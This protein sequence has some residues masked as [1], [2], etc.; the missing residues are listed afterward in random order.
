MVVSGDITEV[1]CNHPTL[2]SFTFFPKAAED[3]TYDL[4]GFRSDDDKNLIDGG[5]G[6]IDK[7]N[8]SRWFFEVPLAS[9]LNT[10][11]ELQNITNLAGSPVPGEWT[12]AHINGTVFKGTGKPVGDVQHNGNAGT[13]ALKVSGGGVMKKIVG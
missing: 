8:R 6:V 1:T 3:S 4:G 12:F 2:G 7:M 13:M 10:R 5:G 9:D 11:V